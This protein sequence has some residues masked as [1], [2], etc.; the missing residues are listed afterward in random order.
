MK[1]DLENEVNE[2]KIK[3]YCT[4]T[5]SNSRSIFGVSL[6]AYNNITILELNSLAI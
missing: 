5:G 1:N 3:F 2:K 6:K 4:T